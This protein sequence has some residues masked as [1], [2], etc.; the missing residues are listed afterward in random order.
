MMPIIVWYAETGFP[1]AVCVNWSIIMDQVIELWQCK[2]DK[3][4]VPKY[5]E[6]WTHQRLCMYAYESVY[7]CVYQGW[8]LIKALELKSV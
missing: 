5:D 6:Q 3:N 8:G 4:C 7:V 1:L 2:T